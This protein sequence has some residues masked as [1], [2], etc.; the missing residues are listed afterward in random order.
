MRVIGR[1]GMGDV[2]DVRDGFTTE[3]PPFTKC[4]QL[5]D[6]IPECIICTASSSSSHSTKHKAQF[7]TASKQTN[8]TIA[9]HD[10]PTNSNCLA[11]IL[12]RETGKQVKKKG[13]DEK[14]KKKGNTGKDIN[15]ITYISPPHCK[16]FASSGFEDL[17][18]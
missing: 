6:L 5:Q 12:L 1:W 4:S 2:V 13:G 7:N 11:Q 18:S 3:P 16:K 15:S 9:Q 17:C 10:A 14:R 8:K